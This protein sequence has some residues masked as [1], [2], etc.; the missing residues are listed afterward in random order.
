[1]KKRIIHTEEVKE[2]NKYEITHTVHEVYEVSVGGDEKILDIFEVLK[3]HMESNNEG[4]DY[5]V[6][7]DEEYYFSD[8]EKYDDDDYYCGCELDEDEDEWEDE[9]EEF[10]RLNN[11]LPN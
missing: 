4:F 10:Y 8:D 1:M 5:D 11:T 3:Q 2:D 7:D 6:E 9:D